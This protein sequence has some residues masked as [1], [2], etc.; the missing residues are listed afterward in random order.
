MRMGR[1]TQYSQCN[2]KITWV[3][4]VEIVKYVEKDMSIIKLLVCEIFN[5]TNAS[6]G[7]FKL[8]FIKPEVK[9]D[10]HVGMIKID[11]IGLEID[12]LKIP[13]RCYVQGSHPLIFGLKWVYTMTFGKNLIN[14]IVMLNNELYQFDLR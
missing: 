2:S 4:E 9:G 12:Y 1:C 11:D 3:D 7:V 14:K 8:G 13:M 5:I 6:S 10:A